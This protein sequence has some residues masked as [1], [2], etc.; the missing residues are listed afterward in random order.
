MKND[1]L[2]VATAISLSKA[3]IRN[4]KMNLFWAFL[5]NSMGIP[6][7]AGVFY[8]AKGWKLNPMI[9]AA[10]MSMS[11]VCV[12]TNALRLKHFKVNYKE[13]KKDNL[14]INKE[15]NI[16]VFDYDENKIIEN[17]NLKIDKEINKEVN[18]MNETIKEIWIDGMQCNHCK[19]TVEKVLGKIDG[20]KKVEVNLEEKKATITIE[21][22]INYE[23]IRQLIKEE[24][25]EVKEIK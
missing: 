24:G 17:L 8:F 2:D 13:V 20:V 25:F 10:A 15:E 19:M 22:D 21:K 18:Y 1:L 11:S 5:Y 4:I 12:V 23:M 9:G 7:A 3:V 6:L 16:N 14:I